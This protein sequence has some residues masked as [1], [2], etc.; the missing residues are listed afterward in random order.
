MCQV[1]AADNESAVRRPAM[2]PWP[3]LAALPATRDRG[4]CCSVGSANDATRRS[5]SSGGGP[6][7]QT[8][9]PAP[10]HF[11]A[12][13]CGS[14]RPPNGRVYV[15]D[16]NAGFGQTANAPLHV[17]GHGG[18]RGPGTG[19]QFAK[20]DRLRAGDM[21]HG[22]GFVCPGE[23]WRTRECRTVL[24]HGLVGANCLRSQITTGPLSTYLS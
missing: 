14:G 13:G 1:G 20:K 3:R 11:S 19:R 5:P 21:H 23:L 7:S 15:G 17:A 9:N 4:P 16:R 12:F 2:L 18:R 6:A 10:L 24:A 8:G 22:D